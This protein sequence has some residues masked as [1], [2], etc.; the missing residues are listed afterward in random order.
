MAH[1]TA[2]LLDWVAPAFLI[3][4]AAGSFYAIVAVLLLG[5]FAARPLP[6]ASRFPSVT[7]LKPLHVAEP[8]LYDN[9]ASFCRQDYPGPVQIVFGV[10]D[11]ATRRSP[12]SAPDGRLPA[13]RHRAGG[14]YHGAWRQPQD[15]QPHQHGATIRHE[16]VVLADSDIRVDA[17]YLSHVAGRAG[18][19]RGGAGDLPL[20]RRRR[21][22]HLG[23]LAAMGSTTISCPTCS[24]GSASGAPTPAS[25]RP[26]RSA[27][28]AAPDRRLRGLRQPPGRRL[29]DRRRGAGTGD[30][31]RSPHGRQPYLPRAGAGDAAARA[32]L[33]ADDPLPRSRR[34]LRIGSHP[35]PAPRPAGAGL[36]AGQCL[37]PGHGRCGASRRLALQIRPTGLS[38]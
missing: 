26:S 8:G 23:R 7:V 14:R 32:A 29:C 3:L 20:P 34:L 21:R 12:W 13:S 38:A 9:L 27:R 31:L 33:G 36:V 25:V 17:G 15:L 10:Q 2:V 18:A 4:A 19:A 37:G 5:R 22:G 30:K 35:S 16:L 11:A 24:S 28:D 6:R 1:M